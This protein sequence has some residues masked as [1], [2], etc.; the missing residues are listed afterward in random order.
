MAKYKLGVDEFLLKTFNIPA[1]NYE[2]RRFS[3]Q[4]TRI[5]CWK[6]IAIR[7]EFKLN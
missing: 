3:S 1:T 5:R 6:G 2:S 4:D 7:D